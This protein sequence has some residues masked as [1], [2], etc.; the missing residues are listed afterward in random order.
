MLT[1]LLRPA[2]CVRQL[3]V[4]LFGNMIG[5][6]RNIYEH[7]RVSDGKIKITTLILRRGPCLFKHAAQMIP[8]IMDQASFSYFCVC[9]GGHNFR[10]WLGGLNF[11]CLV[12]S[13]PQFSRKPTFWEAPVACLVALIIT[14]APLCMIP[15]LQPHIIRISPKLSHHSSTQGFPY[16]FG[17]TSSFL[18]T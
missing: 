12:G 7:Q 17:W 3:A 1:S 4:S 16:T 14:M 15:Y 2:S 18:T 5:N 11:L 6:M 10:V 9:F 13:L 8:R